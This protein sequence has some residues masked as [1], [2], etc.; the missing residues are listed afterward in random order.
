MFGAFA[1]I[2]ALAFFAYNARTIFPGWAAFLPVVG[3]CLTILAEGYL[4]S[5]IFRLHP[6]AAAIGRI[7]YPL[8]PGIGLLVFPRAYLFR[9]LTTIETA[10]LV[11]AA[12]VLAW[13]T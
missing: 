12:P 9:P 13:L 11:I 5:R 8:Y 2:F 1:F 3:S 7:S 4:V 6:L 10:L